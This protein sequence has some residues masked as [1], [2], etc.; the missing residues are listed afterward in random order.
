MVDRRW[1]L[2]GR[3]G[4]T[5]SPVAKTSSRRLSRA[6]PGKHAAV[7]GEL[8]VLDDLRAL[9]QVPV[10]SLKILLTPDVTRVAAAFRAMLDRTVKRK[11]EDSDAQVAKACRA[12]GIE[13]GRPASFL[14]IAQRLRCLGLEWIDFRVE[15]CQA[16]VERELDVSQTGF[17]RIEDVLAF[18][19]RRG[20]ERLASNAVGGSGGDGGG[21]GYSLLSPFPQTAAEHKLVTAA[22]VARAHGVDVW[23]ALADAD[24]KAAAAAVFGGPAVRRGLAMPALRHFLSAIMA[25]CEPPVAKSSPDRS[26]LE[27]SAA[28]LTPPPLPPLDQAQTRRWTETA[29]S[30]SSELSAIAPPP[31]AIA[32]GGGATA[33]APAFGPNNATT[34][35]GGSGGG[36]CD[37]DAQDPVMATLLARSADNRR[38]L[39]CH[40]NHLGRIDRRWRRGHAE[41]HAAVPTGGD[42]GRAFSL[43]AAAAAAAGGDVGSTVNIIA[44]ITNDGRPRPVQLLRLDAVPAAESM[45]RATLSAL[46]EQSARLGVP[47]DSIT[48]YD[49]A[50]ASA[51]A[52]TP[53]SN[54]QDLRR[55]RSPA[56]SPV[57]LTERFDRP[58]LGAA[59]RRPSIASPANG[60]IGATGAVA[61]AAAAAGHN[62]NGG[63]AKNGGSGS[64]ISPGR[65]AFSASPPQHLL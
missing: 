18:L 12:I 42:G 61:A 46:Q 16:F 8:F 56:L 28:P 21:E 15:E 53:Q 9:S 30:T 23:G 57:S 24:R 6:T 64:A 52:A 44:D 26:A 39:Q 63:G 4:T 14:W 51:G 31:E 38:W 48:L 58:G 25:E 36:G 22:R 35:G 1:D 2:L 47:H 10:A 33:A 65:Y 62:R 40:E 13:N 41:A 55:R 54:H 45:R 43:A 19:S 17:I 5:T 32:V 59:R 11:V 29:S 60:A 37:R 49:V 7:K 34:L 3:M 20:A 27:T 50:L